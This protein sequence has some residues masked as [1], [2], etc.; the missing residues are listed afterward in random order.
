MTT[1]AFYWTRKKIP[2]SRLSFSKVLDFWNG[3]L[4][5]SPVTQRTLNL[6][7]PLIKKFSSTHPGKHYCL[8]LYAIIPSTRTPLSNAPNQHRLFAFRTTVLSLYFGTRHGIMSTWYQFLN[9][10]RIVT[11]Q[12]P[13]HKYT[14]PN[15][16][17]STFIHW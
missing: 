7:H 10:N 4:Y 17:A 14:N 2:F 8:L 12:H 5:I 13:L 9:L 6:R 3:I 16:H 11:F 1:R 15:Q